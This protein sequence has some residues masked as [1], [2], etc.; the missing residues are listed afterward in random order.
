MDYVK[1]MI[2]EFPDY[3]RVVGMG[4]NAV[5]ELVCW[6]KEQSVSVLEKKL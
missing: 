1:S 3:F 5:L 6:C 4:D 2:P